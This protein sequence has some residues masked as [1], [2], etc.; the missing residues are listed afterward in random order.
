MAIFHCFLL[1]HQRVYPINTPL[2]HYKIPLDHYKSQWIPNGIPQIQTRRQ[3]AGSAHQV[4][5][6]APQ[7][8]RLLAP[9]RLS[10]QVSQRQVSKPPTKT[11]TFCGNLAMSKSFTLNMD[12]QGYVSTVSVL[13]RVAGRYQQGCNEVW[14]SFFWLNLR[15][16]GLHIC[17]P[18]LCIVITHNQRKLGCQNFR[19]TD[20][21]YLVHLTMMKGG[22]SCNNT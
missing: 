2:N 21:F 1:V 3:V 8:P 6:V 12:E 20:D 22:R 18:Q 7:A 17:Y 15:C 10:V 16:R 11:L 19:V 5:D 13:S 9:P 14:N 4:P